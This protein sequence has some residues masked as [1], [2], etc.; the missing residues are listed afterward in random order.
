[1]REQHGNIVF[2]WD[3][4]FFPG[5]AFQ[6]VFESKIYPYDTMRSLKCT[7]PTPARDVLVTHFRDVPREF[8][9][10][11]ND[12][13]G[14]SQRCRIVAEHFLSAWKNNA[15]AYNDIGRE[16][17]FHWKYRSKNG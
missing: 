11:C 9:K 14:N 6:L 17:H 13:P 2:I 15:T 12:C 1:M 16:Y 3:D 4:S 5:L 8:P 7:F 10:T